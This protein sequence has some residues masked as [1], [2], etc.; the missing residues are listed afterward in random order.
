MTPKEREDAAKLLELIGSSCP[1]T[2]RDHDHAWRD[3]PRCAM[4]E[5]LEQRGSLARRLLLSAAAA[6][7]ETRE[8]RL[9][10]CPD[11]GAA[12]L[13]YT[14]QHGVEGAVCHGCTR[15]FFKKS[16]VPAAPTVYLET[17]ATTV[18]Y[19]PP[20]SE[21]MKVR[22]IPAPSRRYRPKEPPAPADTADAWLRRYVWLKHGCEY[23]ALYGDD[24][25]MQCSPCGMD[26]RR[27]TREELE[28]WAQRRMVDAIKSAPAATPTDTCEWTSDE[29]D[30]SWQTS[31]G[32]DWQFIDDGPVENKMQF[33]MGCG[34]PVSVQPKEPTR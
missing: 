26:F 18:F 12:V 19:E 28:R 8:T 15:E 4:V 20:A 9:P 23:P 6:L 13:G 31:C 33:C 16:P 17:A 11:C 14:D 2:A 22:F 3:C 32:R 34:K 25:E 27:A 29:D 1:K 21:P 7:R 24:G 10:D 5:E 30:S